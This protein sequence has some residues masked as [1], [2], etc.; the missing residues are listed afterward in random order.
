M[1]FSGYLRTMASLNIKSFLRTLEQT[2]DHLDLLKR[3]KQLNQIMQSMTT[4]GAIPQSLS[5]HYR[6]GPL[7]NGTLILLAN[8]ASV[9]AKLKH[10]S[11]S[12]L[13]KIRQSGWKIT[14]IKI[15]LQ[16]P[17][18][19]KYK[20]VDSN[21][22]I[23][24]PPHNKSKYQPKILSQTGV[25]NLNNLAHSLPDS[26]LKSSIQHLLKACRKISDT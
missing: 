13:S 11:P 16:K 25:E 6:L 9:A 26:E 3:A 1:G 4:S 8:N 7:M 20:D 23:N 5:G 21:C 10:I 19:N 2:S 17:D 12:I 24:Q 14:T 22:P 15:K 18:S